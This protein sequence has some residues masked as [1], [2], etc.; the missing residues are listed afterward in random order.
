M[1]IV[2]KPQIV[3]YMDKR[4]LV[5]YFSCGKT[6]ARGFVEK[7]NREQPGGPDA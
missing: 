6:E 3:M 5:I 2:L 7:L 1:Y 4:S